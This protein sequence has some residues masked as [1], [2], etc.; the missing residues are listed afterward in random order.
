MKRI[1]FVSVSPVMDRK[2]WIAEELKSIHNLL[3]TAD[4]V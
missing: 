2:N 3:S 1:I 4:P